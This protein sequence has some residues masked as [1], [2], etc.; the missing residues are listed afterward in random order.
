MSQKLDVSNQ[1]YAKK[2][3]SLKKDYKNDEKFEDTNDN[4]NYKLLV[5][6]DKCKRVDILSKIYDEVV[7]IMFRDHA[8]HYFF[9][10]RV[11][12]STFNDFCED[13]KFFFENFE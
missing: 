13:M 6:Y 8:Q 5:F 1:I 12:F 2:L 4:F 10:N 9:Q 7:S 11:S 3:A